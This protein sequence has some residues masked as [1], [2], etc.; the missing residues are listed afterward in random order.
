MPTKATATLGWHYNDIHDNNSCVIS[1]AI[2]I[3]IY[4]KSEMKL[5]SMYDM[6][7]VWRILKNIWVNQYGNNNP[8]EM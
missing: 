5:I 4:V 7:S 6:N 1:L 3:Y 8:L 2:F